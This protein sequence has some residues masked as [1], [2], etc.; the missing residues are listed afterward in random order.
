MY[1]DF[2]STLTGGLFAV[3][4]D[5]N[6]YSINATTGAATLV[7]PT[8]Q[9]VSGQQSA[10]SNNSNTLYFADGVNL[11]TID[12]TTGRATPLGNMG[13]GA[14][15]G[16]DALLAEGGNLYGSGVPPH[17]FTLDPTTGLATMGP[18][19]TGTSNAFVG[20]APMCCQRRP[21]RPVSLC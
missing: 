15:F 5:D 12:T 18:A 21:S 13:L 2:G 11:Y 9:L 20:L 3:G 14:G 6:L 4:S 16:M 7:G 19:V 8:G 10:L 1:V 17:I